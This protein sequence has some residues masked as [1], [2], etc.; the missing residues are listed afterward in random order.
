[1]RIVVKQAFL[2]MLGVLLT[3]GATR[4]E[5]K[6]TGPTRLP[7]KD[8]EPVLRQSE[9]ALGGGTVRLKDGKECVTEPG[10]GCQWEVQLTRVEHWGTAPQFLLV[11]VNENHLTGSGAW[12]NVFVHA[13]RGDVFLPAFSGR[14]LYDAKVELGKDFEFWLTAGEWQPNDPTCCPSKQRRSR[15]RWNPKQ[16]TFDVA[17]STV[18]SLKESGH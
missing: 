17:E 9:F 12:D 11:I 8:P 5:Q 7:C 15:Y 18:K 6:E 10:F 2:V 4:A 3:V 14:F 13:C 16:R 1:M